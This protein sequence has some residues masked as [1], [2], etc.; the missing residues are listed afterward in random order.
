MAVPLVALV[1]RAL[2]LGTTPTVPELV[3]AGAKVD[4]LVRAGEW[5][6]VVSAG[7][8]HASL[9]HLGVN[10]ALLGVGL[11]AWT[12]LGRGTDDDGP[13]R[14]VAAVALAVLASV[15][16]FGTSA[17]VA[18]GASVGASAAAHGM[19]AAVVAGAWWHR[20][21]LPDPLARRGPLAL[22]LAFAGVV[23]VSSSASGVD[24]AAHAGGVV[25]GLALAPLAE[26]RARLSLVA[27]AAA[28]VIAALVAAA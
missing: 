5:W 1:W 25:A 16:G 21:R 14:A 22:T 3:A 12:W 15:I 2:A 13:S 28:V 19:L 26:T 4:E 9:F 6:R 18:V 11:A 17:V 23:V 24:H 27:L 7:L 10:L 20:R 8:L